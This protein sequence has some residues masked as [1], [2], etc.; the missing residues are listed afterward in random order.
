MMAD[1][2]DND[3]PTMD[4]ASALAAMSHESRLQEQSLLQVLDHLPERCRN[5]VLWHHRD[6]Q[7]YEEIGVRLNLSPEAVRQLHREAI[8]LVA[9][10][11]H[12]PSEP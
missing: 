10:E 11:L 4:L 9:R 12:Q 5:V 2:P 3:R 1:L 8:A 6:Q 7:N